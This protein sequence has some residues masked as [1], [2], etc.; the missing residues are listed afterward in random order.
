[1]SSVDER[2]VVCEVEDAGRA[3]DLGRVESRL[4]AIGATGLTINLGITLSKHTFAFAF[5]LTQ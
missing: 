5:A 1:M 4:T 2:Q 3:S